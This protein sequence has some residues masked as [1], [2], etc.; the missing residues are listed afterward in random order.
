VPQPVEPVKV[1]HI[2]GLHGTGSTILANILGQTEGVFNAGELAYL[3]QALERHDLCGCGRPVPECEL[4]GRI[5]GSVFSS[6][7]EAVARLR[8]KPSWIDVARL[9]VLAVAERS[10]EP[11]L[12][13]YRDTL[14]ELLAAIRAE[15]GARL[16]VE[17]SKHPPFGR[18][19][20]DIPGVATHVVHLV[21]DPRATTYAWLRR[22][23]SPLQSAIVG[24]MWTTWHATIPRLSRDAPYLAIRYE[25]FARTPRQVVREIL[26]FAGEPQGADP[27][28]DARTVRLSENHMPVGNRN[29]FRTGHVE[30][31]A[32]DEWRTSLGA[33]PATATT[34]TAAPLLRRWGYGFRG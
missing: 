29:R 3:S 15:T 31:T 8:P 2:A 11:A 7:E 30:I 26:A 9:P 19:L 24:A 21:R 25:D 10:A 32:H 4:W 5:L 23:R 28:I 34:I 22:S 17:T 20:V 6:P 33:G 14:V 16:V 12:E 18:V 1:L 13:R 27:F